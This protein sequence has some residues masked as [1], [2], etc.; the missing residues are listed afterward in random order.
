MT[1]KGKKQTLQI[2]ATDFFS[3]LTTYS[4]HLWTEIKLTQEYYVLQCWIRKDKILWEVPFYNLTW[5][6]PEH[7]IVKYTFSSWY[8]KSRFLS[9]LNR[10]DQVRL[11]SKPTKKLATSDFTPSLF[12]F[13]QTY[14]CLFI[15]WANQLSSRPKSSSYSYYFSLHRI[16]D[17][18]FIPLISMFFFLSLHS[19][20]L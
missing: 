13:P 2:A 3:P 6:V 11:C 10:E 18:L 16:L 9:I 14:L 20:V 19:D 7:E 17:G 15:I 1:E 5:F 8:I 4:C 12:S